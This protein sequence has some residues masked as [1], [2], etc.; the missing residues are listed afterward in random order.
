MEKKLN[1]LG[2][3]GG[4]PSNKSCQWKPHGNEQII[5]VRKSCNQSIKTL[6]QG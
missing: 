2:L 1:V 4:L 6:M 3:H 5:A